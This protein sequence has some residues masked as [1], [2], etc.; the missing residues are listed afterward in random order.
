[1]VAQALAFLEEGRRDAAASLFDAARMME[2]EDQEAHNNFG[3][4]VMPDRPNEAL[5][6]FDEV[7][8]LGSPPPITLV[9]RVVAR[10]LAGFTAAALDAGEEAFAALATGTF[11]GYLWDY[12]TNREEP[13]ISEFNLITYLCRF[14][15]WV[16]RAEGL[17]E[18]EETWQARLAGANP[19]D[20]QTS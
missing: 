20:Q 15:A 16:A 2:P 4:C 12:M 6:A 18:S 14:C 17:Q 10:W 3:F 11:Q 1:L 13:T 19:R 7:L 9:N 8:R 5:A